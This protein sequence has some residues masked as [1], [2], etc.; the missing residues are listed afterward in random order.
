MEEIHDEIDNDKPI[1]HALEKSLS[2]I[3]NDNLK[4]QKSEIINI[5]ENDISEIKNVSN[6]SIPKENMNANNFIE[7]VSNYSISSK[8]RYQS[9]YVKNFVEKPDLFKNELFS[10][11]RK[12]NRLES[13]EHN[14]IESIPSYNMNAVPNFKSNRKI[15]INIEDQRKKKLFKI[16][17]KFCS[18]N[19]SKKKDNTFDNVLDEKFKMNLN[20]F[21]LFCGRYNIINLKPVTNNLSEIRSE[22]SHQDV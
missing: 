2:H 7:N 18:E 8:R 13:A 6:K 19:I 11:N 17:C 9:P 10:S 5:K 12:P 1:L 15:K 21:M 14:K 3:S 16:F 22:E 20:S 4:D